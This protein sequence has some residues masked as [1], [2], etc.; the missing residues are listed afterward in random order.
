MRCARVG[1]LSFLIISLIDG[2]CG[3][4]LGGVGRESDNEVVPALLTS[5]KSNDDE[6]VNRA[7]VAGG[8]GLVGAYEQLLAFIGRNIVSSA[9]KEQSDDVPTPDPLTAATWPSEQIDD[10][11]DNSQVDETDDD[12]R[13]KRSLDS[14]Q[15]GG[16]EGVDGVSTAVVDEEDYVDGDD[17]EGED[18][19]DFSTAPY[20]GKIN[21]ND[22]R[23]ED[24][25][26][27]LELIALNARYK[28]RMQSKQENPAVE[29]PAQSDE[30]EDEAAEASEADRL[31]RQFDNDYADHGDDHR[32]TSAEES[33]LDEDDPQLDSE[34]EREA[35][36]P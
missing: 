30:E 28:T 12:E 33:R 14:E 32:D 35:V 25:S 36:P 22:Y 10:G 20:T 13:Q 6:Q 8:N 34:D 3:F 9:G 15:A 16:G 18:D 2:S 11:F 17:G 7:T 4:T 31:H 23:N 27:V 26:S 19:D 5:R 1:I 24:G 29:E 21:W